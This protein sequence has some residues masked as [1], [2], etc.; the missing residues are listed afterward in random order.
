MRSATRQRGRW[1]WWL[2]VPAAAA[3]GWL[4][5]SLAG[6]PEAPPAQ[7]RA[8]DSA[9]GGASPFAAAPSSAASA[10]AFGRSRP[11]SPRELQLAMWQQR[12]ERAQTALATYRNATRYPHGARPIAEQP[13]QVHPNQPITE[14]QAFRPP[15][16]KPSQALKLRSSQERVFVQGLEEVHLSVMVQDANGVPQPARVTRAVARQMPSAG[17]MAN[18]AVM[19][20][21]FNDQGRAGDAQAGD[22]DFGALLQPAAQGFGA[23]QIR[24]E[25]FLEAAGEQGATYFDVF[26]TPRAPAVWQGGVREAV[27]DGSLD[28]YFKAQVNEPGRYVV[29]AR[30]DDAT[31]KPFALLTF[32]DE[33]GSGPQEF[34]LSLFGKLLRDGQP[35]FPLTVRD[36]DGFLLRPDTFP[37]R[38][39][40][41][42]LPGRVHTS[43]VYPLSAFS[44]GEW[45]TE[46]RDRYLA[47]LTRDVDEAQRRVDALKNGS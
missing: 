42:R 3:L 41:P 6:K 35:A 46:E 10:S 32:N 21:D 39:L 26:Y 43:G 20:M 12:L 36:V 13:D 40:M 16:G 2:A 15:G 5:W 14:E 24:V 33:V 9:W 38:S 25:V 28:F 22:L 29:T 19:A 30:V 8:A 27:Q 23:G 45:R 7:A 47:E 31:G 37:D 18:L 11:L 1:S 44:S 34:R 17:A 4:A